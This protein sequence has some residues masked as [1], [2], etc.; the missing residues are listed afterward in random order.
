MARIPANGP[1]MFRL[2]FIHALPIELMKLK[3][4]TLLFLISP[5]E[6][7]NP[8]LPLLL[9][10]L[11]C[12]ILGLILDCLLCPLGNLRLAPLNSPL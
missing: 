11:L 2:M 10:S 7:D 9:E 8:F 5:Y 6:L 12:H 1:K 4:L 3:A